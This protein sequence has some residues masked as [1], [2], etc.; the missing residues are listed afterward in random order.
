MLALVYLALGISVGIDDRYASTYLSLN[1]CVNIEADVRKDIEMSEKYLLL[2][3]RMKDE[4]MKDPNLK[5][6]FYGSFDRAI[7][8]YQERGVKSKDDPLLSK[9]GCEKLAKDAEKLMSSL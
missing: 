3:S 5:N 4:V 6:Y 2:A 1:L 9:S 8:K 7:E